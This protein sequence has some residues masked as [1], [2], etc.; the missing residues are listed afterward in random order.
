MS[1]GYGHTVKT[2]LEP[3]DIATLDVAAAILG[4]SA[5]SLPRDTRSE[6]SVPLRFGGMGVGYLI[7]FADLAH[8]GAAG[9]ATTSSSVRFL[10]A[11]DACVRGD[12]HDDVP[13][14]PTMYG[15]LVTAMFTTVSRRPSAPDGDGGD[16]EPMLSLELASARARLDVTRG[17]HNMVMS[18]NPSKQRL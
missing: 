8:V 16:N 1:K 11:Q 14:E 7:T 13:I 4:L 6:M 3:D 10:T 18:P 12:T 9:L 15:R 2:F 17:S 5:A